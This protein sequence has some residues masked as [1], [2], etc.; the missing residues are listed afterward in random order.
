MSKGWAPY[1]VPVA[2]ALVDRRTISEL[3][4]KEARQ[5]CHHRNIH[6][7]HA[8]F[9]LTLYISVLGFGVVEDFGDNMAFERPIVLTD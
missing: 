7:G 2:A 6:N 1:N 3:N 9:D 5:G 4:R 8:C